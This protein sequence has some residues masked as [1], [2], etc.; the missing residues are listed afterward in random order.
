MDKAGRFRVTTF[1]DCP[2]PPLTPD[3][4]ERCSKAMHVI[5]EG[6][7]IYRGGDAFVFLRRAFGKP[8]AG[9]LGVQPFKAIVDFAYW[10]VSNNRGFFAPFLYAKERWTE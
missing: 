9:V 4:R 5:D 8:L 3:L 2:N 6:G 7:R 10:I 1:Q